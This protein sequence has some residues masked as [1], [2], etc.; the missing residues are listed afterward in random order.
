MVAF[1]YDARD[2]RGLPVQGVVEADDRRGALRE[3]E[4]SGIF[5]LNLRA[6]EGKAPPP[7][8]SRP[9]PAP[10]PTPP[11]P[12][13]SAT[14]KATVSE[15]ATASPA[16]VRRRDLTAWTRELASLLSAAIPIP[17]AL[18]GL[19]EQEENE[20]LVALI[21]DLLD[22]VRGG[23]TLSDA[24]ARHPGSFSG[25]YVSMVRVG[26][27]SGKLD[28]VLTDL[29]DLMESEDEIRGE[30]QGAIAYP[31]FVLVMGIA[32][33]AVLLTVVLPQIFEMFE[34]M[35]NVL[36]LPTKVLLHVSNFLQGQWPWI[37]AGLL[38]LGIGGRLLLR[39]PAGRLRWDAWK[40][41]IPILGPVFRAS[42][43]SRFARTLGTLTR[44]GVNLL[45][46]LQIVQGT[47]G[48]GKIAAGIA[49]VA[50]ETR[51]GD[52]LARPLRRLELFPPTMVQMIHVGEE[53]GQLDSMLLR[54]ASIQ[55]R[56]LHRKT[57]TLISLLAP[58]LILVVGALV[59]FIVIALL[60]PIF[61]MSQLVG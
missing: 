35:E 11:A 52:S 7:A 30:I 22:R 46:A 9:E 33:T 21:R 36:P 20:T 60:L 34:G 17:A 26:E 24:L 32:T 61:Q 53:T 59:G 56:H 48:N 55:E 16:R 14:P 1:R 2:P 12:A 39:T 4:S 51:G 54:V 47:V 50:E 31:A 15:G 23:E 41:E 25:L 8:A 29:A 40:L 27:E 18:E 19:A 37:L 13:V 10:R 3:L 6:L 57:K 58:L 5:P 49:R 45:P 38:A 42:A 28:R 43:L 44:S